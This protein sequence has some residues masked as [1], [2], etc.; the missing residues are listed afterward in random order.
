MGQPA[1]GFALS[2]LFLQLGE[3][4][5]A[6]GMVA[7]DQHRRFGGGPFAVGVPELRAGCALPLSDRRLGARHEAAI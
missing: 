1:E 7:E 5:L 4:L 6:G 2:R 3:G